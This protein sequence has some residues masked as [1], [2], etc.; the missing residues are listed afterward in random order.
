MINFIKTRLAKIQGKSNGLDWVYIN[1]MGN[2]C[3]NKCYMCPL[4]AFEGKNTIMPMETY[5]MAIQQLK[6]MNFKGELHL[7]AQNEPF[8]DSH[9]FEKIE[10]AHD[11][12]PEA[13]IAI[14]SNFTALN[15]K[16]IQ[17]ILNSSLKY[18]SCSIYAL[19]PE[20]YEA[21][22]GRNNFKLSFTNQVKFLKEYAKNPKISFAMYLM[23]DKHNQ[24]DIE[25]CEHFIFDIAPIRRADF[26]ETFT[27]FN[28]NHAPKK[29]N[30]NYINHCIYDR[31]Q[32]MNDGDV[33]LCSIDA[34]S[35]M[36]VGNLHENSLQELLN[37]PQA[38]E[39]RKRMLEDKDEKA[40]CR[41][42]EFGRVENK[43]L[44][45]IPMPQKLRS[46]L[47]ELI[48]SSFRKEHEV[49]VFSDEEISKKLIRFNEIF[50]DGDEDNW[51]NC[52]ENLREEFYSN[53]NGKN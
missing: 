46:Y 52:L 26:Y 33:S 30:K 9:I 51:I 35:A 45:F 47:N 6:D 24:D 48:S 37:S 15:D 1:T 25:F 21:I 44:Y 19:K 10:Y 12:L 42:C 4:R 40:Y 5:K 11:N 16:K 14:I 20:N 49:K 29:H 2:V 23:N 27:F 34:G 31:F 39:I 38:I 13:G 43:Y 36:H 18:F 7:Y 17:N 22:C 8:L 32:I 50:K 3:T 28:T 53:K 41:W